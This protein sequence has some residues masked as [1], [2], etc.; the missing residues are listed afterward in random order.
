M[1]KKEGIN[2]ERR[3]DLEREKREGNTHIYKKMHQYENLVVNNDLKTVFKAFTRN[4]EKYKELIEQKAIESNKDEIWTSFF[5][6][7]KILTN[8][9][10]R[11]L[12]YFN[13]P[14]EEVIK[15]KIAPRLVM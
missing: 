2:K 8:E 4:Y 6:E 3:D 13:L 10:Q 5:G 15:A 11:C 1:Y 9:V 12:V 7:S 14:F